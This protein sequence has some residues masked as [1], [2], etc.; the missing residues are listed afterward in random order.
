M[1]TR[2]KFNFFNI[3]KD[4]YNAVT[5]KTKPHAQ[6]ECSAAKRSPYITYDAGVFGNL[7]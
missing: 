7:Q 1:E 5:A 6:T 3:R 2:L 4:F